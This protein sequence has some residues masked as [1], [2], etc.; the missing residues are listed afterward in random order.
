MKIQQLKDQFES[1]DLDL[2]ELGNGDSMFSLPEGSTFRDGTSVLY[3]ED[4]PK[5]IDA[6]VEDLSNV[7]T[8]H[9]TQYNDTSAFVAQINKQYWS[10]R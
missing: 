3:V 7:V 8:L 1:L 10:N 4:T 2:T 5:G 9:P 6:A